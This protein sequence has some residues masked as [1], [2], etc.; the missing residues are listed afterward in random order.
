[1]ISITRPEIGIQPRYLNDILGKK[2]KNT[3]N[4]GSPITWEDIDI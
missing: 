2:I 4:K 3:I 1:M